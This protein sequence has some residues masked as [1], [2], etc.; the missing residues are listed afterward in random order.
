MNRESSQWRRLSSGG[1]KLDACASTGLDVASIACARP[2]TWPSQGIM[3]VI[4][5]SR[6]VDGKNAC[7]HLK[8]VS[9]ISG[10]AALK[11]IWPRLKRSSS[12]LGV[13]GPR[14]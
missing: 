7:P 1:T 12:G 2:L 8:L 4:D 6:A 10:R 13:R 11:L 5:T 14:N 3:V 9:T